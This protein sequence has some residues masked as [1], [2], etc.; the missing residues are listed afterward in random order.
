MENNF[1]YY[2]GHNCEKIA[3]LLYISKTTVKKVLQIYMRWGAV[4]NLWKKP[5]GRNKILTQDDM[6][7][8]IRLY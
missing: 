1:F 4:V 6:K 2:N 5:L 3:E 8:F 7:V